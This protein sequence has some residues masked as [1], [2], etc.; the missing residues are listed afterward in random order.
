MEIRA[1]FKQRVLVHSDSL[2]WINSPIQGVDRRPLDRVGDEVARATSIVRYAAG[3]KFSAHV[4]T[5]GEEFIVLSGVFQDEHGDFP[6]G[7]YIRN[8]PQ[9]KHTPGSEQGCVIFVKLWQFQLNDRTHVRKRLDQVV[10]NDAPELS[11]NRVGVREALLYCDDYETVKLLS[12][13]PYAELTLPALGGVEV[14]VLSGEISEQSDVLTTNSW[15][16]L[17]IN[18]IL[19]AQAGK[20]GARMWIKSG[21]LHD[22]ENQILRVKNA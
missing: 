15:L 7:S 21:N 16:R 9:S 1:D 20:T 19:H 13:D 18:S 6:A 12:L 14:L 2:D 17:P 5:G 3:S 8:P 10:F 22:V 11:N 4:H